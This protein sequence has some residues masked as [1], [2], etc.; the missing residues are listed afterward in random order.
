MDLSTTVGVDLTRV[1]VVDLT[2]VMG[3][4]RVYGPGGG[5][6]ETGAD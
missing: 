4:D 6:G 3:V 2:R 1:V 5:G